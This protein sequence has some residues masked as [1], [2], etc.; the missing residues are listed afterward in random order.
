MSERGDR[1]DYFYGQLPAFFKVLST[2]LQSQMFSALRSIFST[3]GQVGNDVRLL[4]LSSS[5]TRRRCF[6]ISN[7]FRWEAGRA[8]PFTV[9]QVGAARG[10]RQTMKSP[11]PRPTPKVQVANQDL[12]IKSSGDLRPTVTEEEVWLQAGRIFDAYTCDVPHFPEQER[13]S[14]KPSCF[15]DGQTFAY[16]QSSRHMYPCS[17]VGVHSFQKR[18]AFKN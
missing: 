9:D 3:S 7:F 17:N 18:T 11:P 15:Q 16:T 6:P 10:K 5:P 12:R 4:A 2:G 13:G 14:L 8:R 1:S